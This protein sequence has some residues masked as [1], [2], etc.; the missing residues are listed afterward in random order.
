MRDFEY[1]IITFFKFLATFEENVVYNIEQ[2]NTIKYSN[3]KVSEGKYLLK[4]IMNVKR[5]IQEVIINDINLQSKIE[6]LILKDIPV[7]ISA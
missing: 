1:V 3:V 5:G 2:I 4:K 7:I 6:R